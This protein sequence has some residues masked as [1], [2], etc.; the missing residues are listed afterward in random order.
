MQNVGFGDVIFV[1]LILSVIHGIMYYV[2]QAKKR[3]S[4]TKDDSSR[5]N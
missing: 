4:H 2:A 5:S 1:L 3:K